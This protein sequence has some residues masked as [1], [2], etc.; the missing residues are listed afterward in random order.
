MPSAL[1]TRDP[2]RTTVVAAVLGAIGAG[3]V[4]RASYVVGTLPRHHLD[5]AVATGPE[6]WVY[7]LGVALMVLAWLG[8]GRLVLDSAVTGMAR[9]VSWAAAAMATPLLVAAPVTSQDVWA[10]LGQANVAAHGLNPYSVGPGAVP[11][12]YPAAVAHEWLHSPSPYGPLW[13]WVCRLVV[14]VTDPH[15]WAGMF[16][17]RA[18]AVLG[19]VATGVALARLTRA[20]GGR[21]EVALWLALAS[22]FSLLMLVGAVHNDAV[23]LALLV[24]GVAAAATT[25]SVRRA[26]LVGALMIGA[27]GAIK[28]TA[29]VAL[30][31]LPLVWMRYADRSRHEGPTPPSV[32]RWV[33]AGAASTAVGVA[34]VLLLGVASGYGLGWIPHV[35]DATIGVRWLSFTQQVGNVLHLVAPQHVADLPKD[36]YPLLH[37]LGLAFLGLALVALTLTARRRPPVRTLALAMLLIVLSST[38]PRLWYLLWPLLFL[39]AERLSARAVVLLAAGAS[40]LALWFPASVRPQPPEWLLLVLFAALAVLATALIDTSTWRRTGVTGPHN[41]A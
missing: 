31:F 15:P 6:R 21:P 29:L 37:P 11:G 33:T 1:L 12:P 32:R 19:V 39:V 25:E 18:L 30:P 3:L 24:G 35:G 8:L 40:T 17:L 2:T 38:A 34:F 22:P 28:V 41:Q 14:E 7:E 13:L 23:M 10:Y 4:A 36:R 26:L 20:A 9:R 16:V 5:R 27:A